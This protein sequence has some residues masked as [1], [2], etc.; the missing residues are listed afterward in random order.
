MTITDVPMLNGG[1]NDDV[2]YAYQFG[3]ETLWVAGE[4]ID[5][6]GADESDE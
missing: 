4:A 1:G 2:N 3:D 5:Q 6:S